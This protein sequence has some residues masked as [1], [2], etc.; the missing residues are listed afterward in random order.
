MRH[1]DNLDS[2]ELLP[3]VEIRL[4]G[5]IGVESVPALRHELDEAVALDPEHVIVEVG[6]CTGLAPE[7]IHAL[8]E[9]QASCGSLVLRGVN[10][11][12][13]RT[14]ALAGVL[15]VFPTERYVSTAYLRH[16]G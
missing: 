14:L 12:L 15:R 5:A 8:L 1:H 2:A 7:A 9:A 16:A 13:A 10:P 3:D 6:H 4:A 11:D